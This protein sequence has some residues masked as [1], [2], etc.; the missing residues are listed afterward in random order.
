[1]NKSLLALTVTV[2]ALPALAQ[3]PQTKVLGTYQSWTAYETAA[4]NKKTCYV[5]AVPAKSQGKYASRGATY[6]QVSHRPTEKVVNEVSLTAGY[7]FKDNA[8]V[9]VDVGKQKFE[10]FTKNDGAWAPDSKADAAIV[11]AMAGAGTL[12]VKGTSSR[13]TATVDTYPLSGFSAAHAEINKACG[14]K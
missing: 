1:M 14:V 11:K 8:K 2:A 9:E 7:T 5:Y 6:I 3:Q 10:L 12:V 13:G 4:G